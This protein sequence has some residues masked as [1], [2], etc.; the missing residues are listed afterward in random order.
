[1]HAD[2]QEGPQEKE[3]QFTLRNGEDSAAIPNVELV[4]KG[5]SLFAMTDALG[6]ALFTLS[7]ADSVILFS[8][9][10]FLT[11]EINVRNFE[12]P[13]ISF[14]A[15]PET[16]YVDQGFGLRKEQNKN[17]GFFQDQSGKIFGEGQFNSF[18]NG[19]QGNF[20][21]LHATQSSGVLNAYSSILARGLAT[22]VLGT[23]PLYVVDG[24]PL[25]SGSEGDGGGGIGN[26]YGFN[27]SPLAELNI[28]DIEKIQY[29][30]PGYQTAMFGARG[31]NGVF[32]VT[33]KRGIAGR[34]R[35][36][37]QYQ[38]GISMPTNK[39]EMMNA[40]KYL[41]ALDQGA[42]NSFYH[43][44]N[45]KG[46]AFPGRNEYLPYPLTDTV[47]SITQ[48]NWLDKILQQG[49]F[50]QVQ[51]SATGGNKMVRF[52]FGGGYQQN[53]G[54]LVNNTF[55]RLNTRFNTD[56]TINPYLNFGSSILVSFCKGFMQPSGP[57]TFGGGFGEAQALALPINPGFYSD[58]NQALNPYPGVNNYF[59]AYNG[60]NIEQLTN[61][62]HLSL[63]RQTFRNLGTIYLDFGLPFIKN[64]RFK[65]VFG[66]DYYSNFD[67]TFI[68]SQARLGDG[69]NVGADT[70]P[71]PS[72]QASDNRSVFMNLSYNGIAEYELKIGQHFVKP[73][74]GIN[75]QQTVNQFNGISSQFFPSSYSKLVSF[76]SRFSDL[77]IGSESGFAFMNYS[78]GFQ[79]D[80]AK[81][82]LL[83]AVVNSTAS[84][85]YGDKVDFIVLPSVSIAWNL[86]DESWLPLPD[87]ISSLRL[88]GA[89]SLSGNSLIGNNSARGYWRGGLP[90]VDPSSYPGQFPLNLA[91]QQLKPEINQ[92][93][94]GGLQFGLF[95]N[96][97]SASVSYFQRTTQNLIQ[98]FPFAPSQGIESGYFLRNDG[99]I[100]NSGLEIN[101]ASEWLKRDKLSF[102]SFVNLGTLEHKVV[103]TAG[104]LEN[105]GNEF[106]NQITIQGR[107]VGTF[108][109]P[110]SGGFA[111]ADDPEGK[112]VKGDELIFDRNGKAF[113][114]STKEE[115]EAARV[116]LNQSPLPKFYGGFGTVA[117][118]GQFS[119]DFQ[120]NFSVGNNILDQ[121]EFQTSY[122]RGNNNL[123]ADLPL[124][125]LNYTGEFA[126]SSNPYQNLLSQNITDRFL[127]D[128]SYLR[129]RSLGLSYLYTNPK[130]NR[131]VRG[132]RF[133]VRAQNVLTFTKFKG[134]DPEV[135]PNTPQASQRG[136]GLGQT[137]FDLP[138]VRQFT[139]GINVQL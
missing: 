123:R 126:N 23:E 98:N 138:Q 73:F 109:L 34:T 130:L 108:Y 86:K 129:L 61:K 85:R 1:M 87:L 95:K 18:E 104:L 75:Y 66:F 99:E 65:G 39:V 77:P 97:V 121:S 47:A 15:K 136:V 101:I 118:Y 103:S 96:R 51:A 125:N 89:W 37:L 134:W 92:I 90:Y 128:A 35:L 46:L 16:R 80:F 68:S 60:S 30:K 84:T 93:V 82:Y 58:R 115:I 2:A 127:H 114:P 122:L 19:L 107:Y 4:V 42:R 32:L 10:G 64:L 6:K 7:E 100:R 24:A 105:Q 12:S 41:Q 8:H 13:D 102:Q 63:E 74:I 53:K 62:D 20:S 110:R 69:S 132:I 49:T 78:G 25:T 14:F 48:N 56:I 28:Q 31:A 94:E 50:Q 83:D 52:F 71:R 45:N 88:Y 9:P 27:T 17:I 54:I 11:E 91:S 36:N 137:L 55:D 119:L 5:R 59:D 124:E 79:Y 33:T 21:G 106:G 113:K 29:L 116:A 111:Q 133:F 38:T 81:R 70:L 43:N 26:N 40:G 44:G 76:G 120:F 139:V 3:Y 72:S 22:S 117:S 135:A 57:G 131:H 67:R 112:F